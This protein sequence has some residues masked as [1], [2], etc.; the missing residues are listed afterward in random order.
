MN[1]NGNFL[2]RTLCALL[3]CA[4]FLGYFVPSSW[5]D[6]VG[7][8]EVYD[9]ILGV[10]HEGKMLSNAIIGLEKGE[11]RFLPVVELARIVGVALDAD[12]DVG[13][14]DGFRFVESNPFAVDLA[15]GTYMVKGKTYPYSEDELFVYE[16]GYGAKE[17]FATVDFLNKLWNLDFELDYLQ[18]RLNINTKDKLLYQIQQKRE[19]RRTTRLLRKQQK[20]AQKYDDEGVLKLPNKPKMFSLPVV[21]VNTTLQYQAQD[22]QHRENVNFSGRNDFAYGE[23]NYNA[24]LVNAPDGDKGLDNVRVTYTKRAYDD[25][26]LPADLNLF[27]AGDVTVR[28]SRLVDGSIRG[29]GILFTNRDTKRTV[30]FDTLVV[31]GVTEPG[32]EVEL[33]RNTELLGFQIA[34]DTGEYRFENVQLNYNRTVIKTVLYGPQGQ[35]E[36]RE[37]VYNISRDRLKP[38]QLNY[39]VGLLDADRDLLSIGQDEVSQQ[40]RGFAKNININ[41]GLS[42]TATL[43][44]T[45]TDMPTNSG[46]QRYASLGL[47]FSLFDAI[48]AVEAYRSLEGGSAIDFSMA[49]NFK[50]T[51]LNFRA[52]LLNDFESEYIGYGNRADILNANASASRSFQTPFGGL[53]LSLG[54]DYERYK[55]KTSRTRFD[56]SQSLSFKKFR[57]TNSTKSSF[58]Q[59]EHQYTYGTLNF[60]YSIDRNWKLRALSRYDIYPEYSL[61]DV[62]AELR[63]KNRDGLTAAF[64]VNRNFENESSKIGAQVGYDFEHMHASVDVDWDSESGARALLRSRFSLAPF[65][66]NSKYIMSN[67]NLTNRTALSG[68][69]FFDN[70]YDGIFSEGDEPIQGANV[71]IGRRSSD[72]SNEDGGFSYIGSSKNDYEALSVDVSSVPEPYVVPNSEQFKTVLRAGQ[73]NNF[74]V[75]VI[76]TGIVEGIVSDHQGGIASIKVQL[77]DQDN[78]LLDETRAAFDGYYS[79]EY[80]RPG[81]YIVQV[82]PEI[83]QVS[84]PPRSVSVTSEELFQFGID[85]QT[86]EQAAEAACDVSNLDGGITQICHDEDTSV[87]GVQQPALITKGEDTSGVQAASKTGKDTSGIQAIPTYKGTS[88]VRVS[89]VRIGEYSDKLRVVLDLSAPT[90]IR[91]WEQSDRKQVTLEIQ[92]VDWQA[93]QSWI[94][95]K[96]HIIKDFKVEKLGANGASVTINAA[97]KII[98]D[99]KMMLTPNGKN[100]YRFYIDFKKCA[101]GCL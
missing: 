99:N 16:L 45:L 13:K 87:A 35:I 44:S 24:Q 82:D 2:K 43:F 42:R 68:R 41:Y 81:D 36:T 96:P 65:G 29:R 50:G 34:S 91:T 83:T 89:K 12:F 39:E 4:V 53:G 15:Q 61:R 80:V 67:Q 101:D 1:H 62:F 37:D 47:K 26:D 40:P 88:G 97:Q 95:S 94:N 84:I 60:Q 93:M 22:S 14:I 7:S 31:E 28:P 46:A 70:D 86:L 6:D 38:G 79:F 19:A 18:A 32:W 64:D 20:D 75:P 52:A 100:F 57:F 56:S 30:E 73:Y 48:G 71:K 33:Y 17:V 23:V 59:V 90:A 5:A 8:E 55:D 85:L 11:A 98:I 25:G 77:L 63:Y 27:Q 9:L 58:N 66:A 54:W 74:D 69:I 78:Q 72:V 21:D 51:N 3:A 49:R 76:R 92:D 10:K